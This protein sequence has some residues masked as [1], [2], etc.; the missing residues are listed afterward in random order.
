MKTI[1][2]LKLVTGSI[3]FAAACYA[4]LA[5]PGF[6][7]DEASTVCLQSQVTMVQP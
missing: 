7:S 5:A 2:Y 4:I 1:R 6:L 3:L